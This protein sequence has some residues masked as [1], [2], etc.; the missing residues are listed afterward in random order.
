MKI[1]TDRVRKT[2][3]KKML[4]ENLVD[5]VVHSIKLELA[6]ID[7]RNIIPD[8]KCIDCGV[9]IPRRRGAGR[10][11]VLCSSC[12][13]HR[14]VVSNKKSSARLIPCQTCDGNHPDSYMTPHKGKLICGDCY[15]SITSKIDKEE[16][17]LDVYLDDYSMMGNGIEQ[18]LIHGAPDRSETKILYAKSRYVK[19]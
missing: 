3:L 13:N 2:E 12:S 15:R 10:P 16:M 17:R 5:S 14:I 11:L 1:K 8:I 9:D 18:A 4:K 7:K 19:K 6:Q